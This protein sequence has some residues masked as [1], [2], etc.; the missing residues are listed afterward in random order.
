MD[1]LN[2]SQTGSP[3]TLEGSSISTGSRARCFSRNGRLA[4]TREYL[5]AAHS[6][7]RA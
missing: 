7:E 1:S 5:E 4:V 2:A 3:W 6:A